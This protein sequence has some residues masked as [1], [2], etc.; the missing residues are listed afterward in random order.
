MYKGLENE[1]QLKLNFLYSI[2]KLTM[3]LCVYCIYECDFNGFLLEKY[4]YLRFENKK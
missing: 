3:R 1:M 4:F 2:T